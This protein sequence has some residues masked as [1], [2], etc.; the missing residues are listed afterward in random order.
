MISNSW[1]FCA[2]TLFRAF[3]T[4]VAR[5]K[6]GITTDMKGLEIINGLR[7]LF[8]LSSN[9]ASRCTSRVFHL[10]SLDE[11]WYAEGVGNET[12]DRPQSDVGNGSS[13]QVEQASAKTNSKDPSRHKRR[14][15]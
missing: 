1:Y 7:S 9:C 13:R 3:R 4:C 2:S 5:L 15:H 10:S 14:W 8:L 12:R 11:Y 6:V